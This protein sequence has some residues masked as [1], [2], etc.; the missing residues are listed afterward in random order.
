MGRRFRIRVGRGWLFHRLVRRRKASRTEWQSAVEPPKLPALLEARRLRRAAW[1]WCRAR[2][3]WAVPL[4]QA[5]EP[6]SQDRLHERSCGRIPPPPAESPQARTATTIRA[7]MERLG[8]YRFSAAKGWLK[9]RTF[10]SA[11]SNRA[12][13]RQ[14]HAES[15]PAAGLRFEF[16]PA[17]VQLHKP[18]RIR[19][20]DSRASRARREEK[21]KNLLLVVGRNSFS[22][23]LHRDDGEFAAASQ[24][25]PDRPAGVGEI[26]RVQQQIQHAW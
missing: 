6:C 22:G 3:S 12:P 7:S 1:R 8:I 18:K 26:A 4:P 5:R 2:Y 9:S 11:A 14:L 16:Y 20:S 23:I 15:R 21:L 24:A 17:V 19:Q 10:A 25:E 13:E